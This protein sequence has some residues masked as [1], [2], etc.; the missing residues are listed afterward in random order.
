MFENLVSSSRQ[1][2]IAL[3]VR[4]ASRVCLVK[5]HIFRILMFG[6]CVGCSILFSLGIFYEM[7]K[8]SSAS[9]P[10]AIENVAVVKDKGK[11][12]SS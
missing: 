8:I 3:S 2:N 9:H 6:L 1:W 11:K 12:K 4:L 5:N 10:V 7:T